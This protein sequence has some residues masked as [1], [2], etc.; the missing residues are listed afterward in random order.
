MGNIDGKL[1][2]KKEQAMDLG[3]QGKVALVLASSKG[4]GRAIAISLAKEG[5]KVVLT[6][7]SVELLEATAQEIK[8]SGGFAYVLPWDL[9]QLDL[10]DAKV[11]Q[12]EQEVGHIDILINNSGGPPM[13][14]AFNQS[15]EL[16]QTQF[17]QMVLMIMKITDRVLPQMRANKW[18][19]I[20]TTTSSGTVA[21]IANLAISNT[22]RL[23]LNGWT[24]TLANEVASEGVTVNI[25][26][27]GRILTERIVHLDEQRSKNEGKPL[28]EV[29]QKSVSSIPMKRYGM[30]EEYADA[31]TFLASQKASY[32]TGT[33]LRVDGGSFAGL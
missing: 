32:I 17:N 23:A 22:L 27:P 11:T 26:L 31:A 21:P 29:I 5:A 10:I 1:T 9:H 24:K 15:I 2:K 13:S 28:E 14:Q 12:I 33:T 6:G 18:G 20:I 7:R 25:I 16:W 30:P 3:I 4:L 8:A 19:R